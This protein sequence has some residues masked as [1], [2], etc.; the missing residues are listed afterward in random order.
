MG[1]LEEINEQLLK[2]RVPYWRDL[3]DHS[4]YDS[5][6]KARDVRAHLRNLKP[7]VM[8]VGGW[9]DAED[10]FGTLETY[11]KAE[12]NN[13]STYNILVMG[14]WYHGQWASGD[15]D[16][17]GDVPF[18]QNTSRWYREHVEFPY[19]ERILR[20]DKPAGLAEAIVYETGANQWRHLPAWPPKETVEKTLHLQADGR[21][22]WNPSSRG[23]YVEYLSDPARPVPSV[24]YTA[25]TMTVD[26]MVA[27]QRLA[28]TR[29]D[30]L[31]F[32][33]PALEEDLTLAGPLEVTLRVS[34]TGTDADFVVKLIDVYPNDY[35]DPNPNP[36]GV[37]MGG[38]QQLVRGEPFRGK[39]RKSFEKPEPFVPGQMDTISFRMPDVFHTFRRG[40]RV[41]VQVQSSW[42]PLV[43]RNPQVFLDIAKA[44]P[45]DFQKATQRVYFGP[46]GG[47]SIT[48]RVW[49]P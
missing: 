47:S 31:V 34:T 11:K 6:W 42:F 30:V 2:N 18:H 35:P 3:M 36:R 7:A 48:V 25:N 41:M 9:Y 40:H 28:A 23:G 26:Y 45:G 37:R 13:P 46:V 29:P 22:G 12:A 4:T 17:L 1:T 32:A 14:P 5:F 8:T 44:K 21:L 15:G 20:E 16:H 49:K 39:F 33:M 10:L 38:Y 27:D 43:D 19:F 24:P